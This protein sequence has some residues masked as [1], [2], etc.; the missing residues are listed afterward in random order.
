MLLLYDFVLKNT[1]H[2]LKLNISM[3]YLPYIN[4]RPLRH[5]SDSAPY[6]TSKKSAF[7]TT[8]VNIR[9]APH[10]IKVLS[11]SIHVHPYSGASAA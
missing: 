8:S 3:Y 10:V 2:H 6:L 4:P 11:N 9:S 7:I 5:G 1:E